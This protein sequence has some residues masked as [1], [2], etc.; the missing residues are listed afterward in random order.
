MQNHAKIAMDTQNGKTDYCIREMRKKQQNPFL[1][2]SFFLSP[3]LMNH[4]P[5]HEPRALSRK[6]HVLSI[7]HFEMRYNVNIFCVEIM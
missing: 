7:L 4:D 1:T 5:C 6:P 2:G 3:F